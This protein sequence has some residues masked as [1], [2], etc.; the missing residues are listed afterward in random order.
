MRVGCWQRKCL[1]NE[2]SES[3]QGGRRESFIGSLSSNIKAHVANGIIERPCWRNADALQCNLLAKQRHWGSHLRLCLTDRPDSHCSADQSSCT[4]AK[5]PHRV[6]PSTHQ[7]CCFSC[8]AERMSEMSSQRMA[9][10]LAKPRRSR[11]E[12]TTSLNFTNSIQ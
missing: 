7:V 10:P 6:S 9:K 3:K 4:R 11:S 2:G 1:V 8:E 12:T 5:W